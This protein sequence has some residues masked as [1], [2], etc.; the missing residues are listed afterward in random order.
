ME[1][2]NKVDMILRQTNYTE[3]E[4]TDK[5]KTM[6]PLEIIREYMNICNKTH[7]EK[8]NNQQK[9]TEIRGFMNNV[10]YKKIQR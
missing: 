2:K 7:T 6:Q 1:Y 9:F 5:L 10:S 8:S 3:N 4:I